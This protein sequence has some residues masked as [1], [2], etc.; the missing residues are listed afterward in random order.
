MTAVTVT[1]GITRW[2]LNVLCWRQPG[3]VQKGFDETGVSE[4]RRVRLVAVTQKKKTHV[5]I[6]APLRV[7]VSPLN[8]RGR[9]RARGSGEISGAPRATAYC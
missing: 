4:R 9:R 5:V 3:G 8:I 2:D 7:K 1:S 6:V